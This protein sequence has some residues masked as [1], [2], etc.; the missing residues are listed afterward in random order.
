MPWATGAAHASHSRGV[1]V[2]YMAFPAVIRKTWGP[3]LQGGCEA[4]S[5][6]PQGRGFQE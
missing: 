3:L 6:S 5:D 4:P 1:H 2:A